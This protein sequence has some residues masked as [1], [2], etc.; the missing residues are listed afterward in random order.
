MVL[1]KPVHQKRW[2]NVFESDIVFQ[3]V[4]NYDMFSLDI[5]NEKTNDWPFFPFLKQSHH[6]HKT[7]NTQQSTTFDCCFIGIPIICVYDMP[8]EQY[9]TPA[10]R[11]VQPSVP[12]AIG[13]PVLE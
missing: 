7:R 12:P 4:F 5:S 3:S 9:T 11:S 6:D 8:G 1:A 13:V 2:I 10:A